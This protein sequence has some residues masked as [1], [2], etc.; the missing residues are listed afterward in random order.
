MFLN[1]EEDGI[2]VFERNFV[3]QTL[4]YLYLEDPR[5]RFTTHPDS[6]YEDK[7]KEVN[8]KL[9][10]TKV[11]KAEPI[12]SDVFNYILD[13]YSDDPRSERI[14]A[15]LKPFLSDGSKPIFDGQT[16]FGKDID[17]D[18]HTTRLVNGK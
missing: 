3:E 4:K 18:I 12:L 10:Q 7:P 15:A 16:Y 2:N 14:L 6:L 11:K 9:I 8:G 17:V 1:Q 13:K 5:F